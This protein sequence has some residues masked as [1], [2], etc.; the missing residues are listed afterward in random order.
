MLR[1]IAQPPTKKETTPAQN[2]A[3]FR[4]RVNLFCDHHSIFGIIHADAVQNVPNSNYAYNLLYL[5]FIF[6]S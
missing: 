5:S 6:F 3:A 1:K 4:E 2:C